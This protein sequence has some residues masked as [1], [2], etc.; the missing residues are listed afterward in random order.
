MGRVTTLTEYLSQKNRRI[1]ELKARI[2]HCRLKYSQTVET[3]EYIENMPHAVDMMTHEDAIIKESF[4]QRNIFKLLYWAPCFEEQIKEVIYTILEMAEPTAF[5]EYYKY[6]RENQEEL[7][8]YDF[9]G[10]N[11]SKRATVQEAYELLVNVRPE[12]LKMFL[13]LVNN[14]LI[15]FE[16]I[17]KKDYD[18]FFSS[19][20]HTSTG[21]DDLLSFCYYE[22]GGSKVNIQLNISVTEVID[23]IKEN[24]Y[25]EIKDDS[26]D[27]VAIFEDAYLKKYPEY[28]TEKEK[29]DF[30]IDL[31][32]SFATGRFGRQSQGRFA[33]MPY[34]AALKVF[35]KVNH[36][37]YDSSV[38]RVAIDDVICNP[39]W[40]NLIVDVYFYNI[41][42]LGFYIKEEVI[43]K[44]NP[45]HIIVKKAEDFLKRNP[46]PLQTTIEPKQAKGRKKSS[47][48]KTMAECPEDDLGRMFRD[49]IWT[50]LKKRL[51]K[52]TYKD[53]NDIELRGKD[54]ETAID[55]LGACFIFYVV[56]SLGFADRKW[57]SYEKTTKEFLTVSRNTISSYIEIFDEYDR[58]LKH[59]QSNMDVLKSKNPK[60]Y[61]ILV[62]NFDLLKKTISDLTP[63]IK[64]LFEENL[65]MKSKG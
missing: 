32:Q 16:Y 57:S 51:Q 43:D 62:N 26:I 22:N 9:T 37:F 34:M 44:N 42:Q 65:T 58:W 33:L 50:E 64:K 8:G 20:S 63:R 48:I 54:L 52:F 13:S 35:C 10:H 39:T 55:A 23:R 27:G 31:L 3:E 14:D 49:E 53:K 41:Y 29:C 25:T 45:E 19:L 5:K 24:V 2:H 18:G 1:D 56:D 11:F 12:R 38:Y 46:Q 28:G 7:V 61:K 47:W 15:L 17:Q 21:L 60:Y 4:I 36:D 30:A 6:I 40:I 59:D